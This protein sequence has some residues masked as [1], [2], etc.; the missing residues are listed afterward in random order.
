MPPDTVSGAVSADARGGIP[1]GSLAAPG[2]TPPAPPPA[3]NASATWH[4]GVDAQT[5][6]WWQNKGLDYANPKDFALALTE[7]YRAAE[8]HIGTPPDQ[9]LRIPQPN[10]ANYEADRRTFNTRL[11]IPAT[12]A[13]YD[14]STVKFSDGTDLDATFAS[15]LS[16]A[17]AAGNVAKDKAATIA[18]AI[19]R[20]E[21]G[22][23]AAARASDDLRLA[24][25]RGLLERNWGTNKDFNL[26]TAMNGARRLGISDEQV[27][28]LRD[29]LGEYQ[30]MEMFR[31]IGAAT[32]EDDFKEGSQSTGIVTMQ[33][34]QAEM[35]RL[36]GDEAFV[37]RYLAGDVDAR[38]TMDAL[39]QQI[40]GVNPALELA[41]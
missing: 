18:S 34:A 26:L 40:T 2:G 10:T 32:S 4:D 12:A 23:E 41:P 31:R 17:F 30:T 35:A 33:G 24:Q 13:E 6:G 16:E 28:S 1:T 27:N 5:L 11:G 7:Q 14:L 9:L 21:E 20:Y 37:K 15:S 29:V 19:I 39:H 38:R 22:R 8:R 36:Q 3:P 25:E